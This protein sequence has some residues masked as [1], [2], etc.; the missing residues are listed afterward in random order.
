MRGE[1]SM[2]EST[3]ERKFSD[4]NE[5]EALLTMLLAACNVLLLASHRSVELVALAEQRRRRANADV[6]E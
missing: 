6:G 4:E 5:C 2:L 1:T 3:P